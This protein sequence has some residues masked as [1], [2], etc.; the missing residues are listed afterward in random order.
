MKLSTRRAVRGWL[1]SLPDSTPTVLKVGS[2][3]LAGLG[4]LID[5]AAVFAIGFAGLVGAVYL[6]GQVRRDACQNCRAEVDVFA[7]RYCPTC[8]ARLDDLEAVP[9]LDE[10][11]PE[12]FRPVGL[13]DVERSPPVEAI[14]DGGSYEEADT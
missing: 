14:A 2:A 4:M 8:G 3:G 13:E 6:H 9:P 1:L 5:T 10:R 11:V 7:E 12:R